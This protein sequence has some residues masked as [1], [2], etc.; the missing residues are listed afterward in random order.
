MGPEDTQCRASPDTQPLSLVPC[1]LQGGWG[2]LKEWLPEHSCQVEGYRERQLVLEEGTVS[3]AP[4]PI[5]VARGLGRQWGAHG[6]ECCK[7]V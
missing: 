6:A 5:L 7:A 3:Q 4:R 1:S 2:L